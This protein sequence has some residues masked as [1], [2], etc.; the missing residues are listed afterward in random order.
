SVGKLVLDYTFRGAQVF[1]LAEAAS[2]Y[3]REHGER[4]GHLTTHWENS[5]LFRERQG[6]FEAGSSLAVEDGRVVTCAGMGATIDLALWLIGQHVPAGQQMTT[7]DIMLHERIRDFSTEQPFG[8]VHGSETGDAALDR[9]IELMRAN[10]EDPLPIQEIVRL[11]GVS[12]RSLER[13][14]RALLNATPNNFYRELR[15][16]RANTL[17]MNTTMSVREI[18]LA[19]GFSNGFSGLYKS[20]YG[21]TPVA[22]R[23]ANRRNRPAARRLSQDG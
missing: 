2:R 17:L 8:G 20:F 16:V 4:H 5:A 7:A 1:L 10:I 6:G 23:R 15:M 3:I 14:F 12:S 19:C 22:R 13:R 9:C 11:L 18:G 21:I